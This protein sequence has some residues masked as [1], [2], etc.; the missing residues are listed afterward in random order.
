PSALCLP[1]PS[2]PQ[3]YYRLPLRRVELPADGSYIFRG[4]GVDEGE[5]L[6]E[7]AIWFIVERHASSTIHPRRHAFQGERHLPLELTLSRRE[8]LVREAVARHSREL[9]ADRLT[10][11]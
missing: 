11:T 10:G 6:V 9:L 5:H 1:L 4:D 8:L 3:T 2:R 7:R